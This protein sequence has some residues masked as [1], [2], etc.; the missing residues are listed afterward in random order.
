MMQDGKALQAGTSHNLGQNFSKAFEIQF[1]SREQ[2]QEYVYTTS[3]GVSTRLI[4]ALIMT[5]SDDDGLILPP[6]LA[7]IAAAIVPIYRKAGEKEKVLAYA[8]DLLVQLCG[9][10]NVAMAEGGIGNREILSVPL[11]N[12]PKGQRVVLDLRDTMRPGDKYYYWEQRGTPVRLEVG[13]RDV[14]GGKAMV[15]RRSPREKAP[16]EKATL[17]RA[18]L[19]GLHR[20]MQQELLERARSFRIERTW[21]CD[22]YAEFKERIEGGGFFLM[23]WDGTRETEEQIKNE[24]KATIRCIPFDDSLDT[25]DGPVTTKEAGT[26]PVSGKPSAGRVIFARA[27]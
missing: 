23:H 25:A 9:E 10:E 21:K 11:P 6:A 13:P 2:K 4:G 15:V 5:H 14:D 17:D 3:W 8:R 18:W 27:Y 26:D 16:L 12:S 19:D 22:D 24:T 7:P 20:E 1:L